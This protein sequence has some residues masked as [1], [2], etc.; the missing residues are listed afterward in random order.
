MGG[1]F[2]LDNMNGIQTHLRNTILESVGGDYSIAGLTSD[3]VRIARH[4]SEEP[5]FVMNPSTETPLVHIKFNG[6]D[7][8]LKVSKQANV[9]YVYNIYYYKQQVPTTVGGSPVDHQTAILSDVEK[10]VNSFND[11][12]RSF[13]PIVFESISPDDQQ[14][15]FVL[16]T[17][18]KMHPE[19]KYEIDLTSLRLSVVEI[20][21]TINTIVFY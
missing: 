5:T 18:V 2:A 20:E 19:V 11:G 17:N 21:I 1:Y 6:S 4:M 12:S 15:Q 14:V 3:N 16:A 13:R 8:Q 7:L 9:V 10:I